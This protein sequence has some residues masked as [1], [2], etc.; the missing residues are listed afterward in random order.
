MDRMLNIIYYETPERGSSTNINSVVFSV[1][2]QTPKISKFFKTSIIKKI[3]SFEN[4][5]TF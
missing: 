3:R 1:L 4:T 2:N 5:K